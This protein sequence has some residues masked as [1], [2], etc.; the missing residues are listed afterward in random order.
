MRRRPRLRARDYVLE[1]S[2]AQHKD[3]AATM[4]EDVL[5]T[6]DEQDGIAQIDFESNGDDTPDMMHDCYRN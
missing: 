6:R 5:I 3:T 4:C 2:D 1:I